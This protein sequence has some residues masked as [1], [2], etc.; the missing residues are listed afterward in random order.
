VDMK[1]G[2]ESRRTI[3]E[4]RHCVDDFCDVFGKNVILECGI[5]PTLGKQHPPSV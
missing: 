2:E 1:K 5:S 3:S 4:V